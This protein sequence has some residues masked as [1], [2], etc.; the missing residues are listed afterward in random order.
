MPSAASAWFRWI[1]AA[2]WLLLAGVSAST[3]A[4]AGSVELKS[5]M[6]LE[7]RPSLLLSL[8]R[9]INGSP[10]PVP[11]HHIVLVQTGWQRYYVPMRQVPPDKL[12]QNNSLLREEE[13]VV[14]QVKQ[15]RSDTLQNVGS[16]LAST[17]YDGQ[18]GRRR[19]T[20]ATAKKEIIVVQGITKITPDHIVVNS[21][22]YVWDFGAGLNT[23]PQETI[24]SILNNPL[25]CKPDEAQ[26]RLARARFY[27]RAEWYPQA[28]AELETIARDFP[29]LQERVTTFREE[30]LQLFGRHVLSELTDRRKA[31]Q[32]RLADESARKLPQDLLG[33]TV[34]REVQQFLAAS[35]R[36]TDDLERIAAL[37]GD[38]Q[39]QL[40][41]VADRERVSDVRTQLLVELD[42]AGLDRLR[43]FLQGVIDPQLSAEEKLSLALSGWVIGGEFATT[44]LAKTLRLWEAR[45]LVREYLR[46]ESPLLRNSLFEEL[47]KIES[48]G[49]VSVRQLLKQIPP[50]LDAE[51][52]QP[53][54][55][56]E[57][58]LPTPGDA[59]AVTYQVVLPPEYSPH[60][61]Y[62]CIVALRP[63]HKTAEQTVA[64]WSGTPEAP[65]WAQRRGYIVIA[66]N[67]ASET[68]REY[69]YSAAAHA[70]VLDALRDAKLRFAVDPDRVYLSGHDMGADAAFDIGLAHP[71]VFAGVMPIGGVSDH[72]GRFCFQNGQYTSWYV[73]RG[74]LGRDATAE[75]MSKYFD[76]IFVH[77]AKF[78]LIYV[79]Y[80]GRGLDP[81]ADEL[82]KLFNWM[83]LHT[84]RPTPSEFEYRT[85]RQ[86]DNHPYWITADPLPRTYLLPQPAGTATGVK[87]MEI[88]GDITVG[89]TVSLSSPASRHVLRFYEGLVDFDRKVTIRVNTKSK[90]SKFLEPDLQTLLED[91]RRNSDRARI[92]AVVLEI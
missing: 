60:R 49:P 70:A 16:I 72:Y 1:L 23:V 4:R 63:E 90:F 84:R 22:N 78:D 29:E 62:P 35:Q 20:L 28:F 54:I 67:Y 61:L 47:Q 41:E 91:F 92:A 5:G 37:L 38:L 52:V 76:R 15:G 82:P 77:G 32:Y 30:L 26:D 21:L 79:E 80:L 11:I 33:G 65:G 8:T 7:G 3:P 10:G 53:G 66:P 36:E 13:F 64:W 81:Y 39:S 71:D 25:V 31:G 18:F 9:T 58:T 14:P 6:V 89:N 44:D 48:A 74:E 45:G 88:K 83:E 75:P 12:N 56:S 59:E 42:R 27:L 46:A 19:V 85:L 73:I 24:V 17:P 2:G 40:K 43:P 51:T 34:Q 68:Q 55:P 86:C 57:I 69:P 87:V 50:V